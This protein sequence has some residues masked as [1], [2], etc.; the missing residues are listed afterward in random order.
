MTQDGSISIPIP[1]TEVPHWRIVVRPSVFRKSLIGS[2]ADCLELVTASRV[3]LRGWDY[4]HYESSTS[5]QGNDWVASWNDWGQ[6]CEYWRMYQSGQF[7]HFL[8]FR[9]NRY[10]D[11]LAK[12]NAGVLR[13]APERQVT[14]FIDFVSTVWTLTEVALFAS[15]LVQNP[16]FDLIPSVHLEV[17]MEMV[18]GRVMGTWDPTRSLSG[19]YQSDVPRIVW[20]HDIPR[21]EL[22][23]EPNEVALVAAQHL[24]ERFGWY[25]QPIPV[26]RA[27]QEKLL[28]RQA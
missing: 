16:Q 10:A 12:R 11:Q 21:T 2:L 8:A 3:S 18:E 17:S 19:L 24:F 7:V 15:R 13:F 26:F 1:V 5:G 14:G 23:A 27:D 20:S 22:L 25:A 9:E 28:S 6:H 4:P